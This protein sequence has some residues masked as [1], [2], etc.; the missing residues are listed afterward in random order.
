M[1]TQIFLVV[2]GQNWIP[3][4]SLMA[5]TLY[6]LLENTKHDYIIWKDEDNLG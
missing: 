3:N 6:A 1:T 4:L 2:C 5:Q